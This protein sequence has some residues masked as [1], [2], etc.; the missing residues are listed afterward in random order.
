MCR[1]GYNAVCC[2]LPVEGVSDKDYI[3]HI[4]KHAAMQQQQKKSNGQLSEASTWTIYSASQNLPAVLNDP[5]KGKQ[6]NFL[7]K[8]WGDSFV[9]KTDIPKSPLLPEVTMQHFD[10]Y[11]KKVSRV[12]MSS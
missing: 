1:Y 8:T 3:A 11:L 12:R 6:G 5:T 7:T 10:A 4:S 2:S 9:E